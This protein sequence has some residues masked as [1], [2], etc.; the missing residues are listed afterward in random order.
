MIV[1]GGG[2][3]THLVNG[4]AVLEYS[5]PQYGGGDVAN[6]D[7][8]AKPD[9]KLIEGGYLALQSE[10]HPIEFR[11]VELLNLAGCM[12]RKAMNYKSY[13][14]KSEP[15]R[16]RYRNRGRQVAVRRIFSFDIQPCW[17]DLFSR[18]MRALSANPGNLG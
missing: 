4:E 6:F 17:T 10:S 11:K 3:I 14:V 2:Q 1:S 12:D 9:G 16:C 8:A 7:P 18:V 5:L 15:E 13:Y